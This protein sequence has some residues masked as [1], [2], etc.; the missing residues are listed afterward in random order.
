MLSGRREAPEDVAVL[1]FDDGLRSHY[2]VV[3]PE[4]RSRGLTGVF[5]IAAAPHTQGEVLPVHAIHHLLGAVAPEVVLRDAMAWVDGHPDAL[6]AEARDD[7]RQRYRG[8]VDAPAGALKRMINGRRYLHTDAR[9]AL[10]A[11]L[12][13]R[14]LP[15]LEPSMIY[16]S[17]QEIQDMDAH[18]M[19]MGAHSIRHDSLS[20]LSAAEQR[21]EIF[22][23]LSW[24]AQHC[25]G[26]ARTF[27]YPYGGAESFD[28]RSVDLLL[29]A[30]VDW[31][32]SLEPE[33]VAPHH[34]A[35]PR[36]RQALPRYDC[37]HFPH[38]AE[39]GGLT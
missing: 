34:L 21:E 39:V 36:A 28:E 27:A 14:H 5:Y 38:G 15:Q 16:L 23:S 3:Y 1:T 13:Q 24:V 11:S 26:S 18:G 8:E 33:D 17:P 9:W 20:E 6:R 10:T 4:L 31:C 32:F 37:R 25:R 19:I 7:Y 2:D 30:G 35:D 22:E 29:E 12:L